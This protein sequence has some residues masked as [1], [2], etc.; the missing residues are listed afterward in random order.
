VWKWSLIPAILAGLVGFGSPAPGQKRGPALQKRPVTVADAIGMTRV[1]GTTFPYFSPKTGFAVFSP[2]G[3]YFA[4][5]ISRGDLEH[6]ANDYSL[7]VFRSDDLAGNFAPKTLAKFASTS[8][9]AGISSVTW[10]PDNDTILFLGSTGSDPTELYS[11]RYSTGKLR[12]LTD[13]R[14]SLVSYAMSAEGD[15]LVYA[16]QGP[17][18][19]IITKKTLR[20][21]FDVGAERVSDLIRGVI[22]GR[23]PEIFLEKS[24]SAKV[25]RVWTH[26]PFDSGLNELFISPDGRYLLVKTDATEL[27]KSWR[28][29]ANTAIQAVFRRK[30]P[31]GQPTRILRYE[32][33]DLR[34]GSSSVLLDA[35]TTYSLSD[36]LWAPDSKSVLLC[37]TYLP[38]DVKDPAELEGRRTKKFVVEIGIGDRKITPITDEDL[39]PLRWD[40]R[41]R[42][43]SFRVRSALEQPGVA[44][45]TV[46]YQKA[47][48]TWKR[49]EA[50]ASF[51]ADA[52]PGVYVDEDLNRPPRIVLMDSHSKTKVQILNLDPQFQHLAFG[53]EQEI[54]WTGIGGT[55]L[56]GG[57]YYPPDYIP[58][59]R[60]PLV[61]Q[62]HG[63]DPHAFWI[64]GPYSSAFAAQPMAS[65][66]I[67]V[68]QI[69]DIFSNTLD[70]PE[71]P[72]R[73]V[74]A[75]LSAIQYL[76]GR[77]IIDHD[78]VGIIGFS[79]TCL[80]VKYALTHA[81][82]HFAAAVITDGVDGG[83]FQYLLSYNANPLLASEFDLI[84][85]APPF[86]AGLSLWVKNSPG[87]LMD[88][89]RSPILIQ[90]IGPIS[91]LDE[92]QWFT[93]LKRLGEPVDL[94]YLPTG[95]HV[96]VKPWGRMASQQGTVDWFCFWLKDEKGA[97]ST[98]A[99]EFRRWRALRL[100]S[101]A[102]R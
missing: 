83:Y 72:E 33:I 65:R 41:R 96:L 70:T 66:G 8:N 11:V 25:T 55:H 94:V 99:D 56:T 22:L 19:S 40:A 53:R 82:G 54:H 63:F 51:E 88:K 16:A 6:D 13:H 101:R 91:I 12:K 31:K 102:K 62:T 64:D 100:A 74:N 52:R 57:L 98:K 23:Q 10:R 35:P 37:G 50:Q 73:A 30:L 43:V 85:G 47:G 93:G 44:P 97:P 36:V 7:L 5:V 95:T 27:H 87:F 2:N 71:E 77:G 80:Y 59:K 14:Q 9:R 17:E 78:R 89:V 29:Y 3:K 18:R 26:D 48:G 42:I 38:L 49:L 92:W 79:R 68:L 24:G 76:D 28:E 15:H 32:L 20:Y 75:Y 67:V 81:S 34:N 46:Y 45:Q 86:G 4:V 21:G 58:G 84:I 69:N 61:I 1:V 90:A 60:Y 39:Q